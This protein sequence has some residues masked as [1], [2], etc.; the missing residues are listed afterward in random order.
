M[1]GTVSDS[2]DAETG[3]LNDG[4]AHYDD[5]VAF[6]HVLIEAGGF[7]ARELLAYFEKPHKWEKE[8][9]RWRQL[10]GTLDSYVIAEMGSLLK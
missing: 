4:D 5:I 3:V 7:N 9:R 1:P 6:G 10:G 8:Y 2:Y